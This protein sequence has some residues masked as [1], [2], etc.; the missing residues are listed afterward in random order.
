MY[1]AVTNAPLL[2]KI[3]LYA[4]K[5]TELVVAQLPDQYAVW[6]ANFNLAGSITFLAFVLA[7]M[8]IIDAVAR[9][10][11]IGARALGFGRRS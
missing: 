4:A 9:L 10:L 1:T 8:L 7:A 6:A 5:T 3:Q 2:R 11:K